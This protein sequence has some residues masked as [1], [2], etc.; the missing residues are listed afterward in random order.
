CQGHTAA[1]FLVS[2][3]LDRPPDLLYDH[4]GGRRGGNP[5]RRPRRTCWRSDRNVSSSELKNTKWVVWQAQVGASRQI[6]FPHRHVAVVDQQAM[7]LLVH[8]HELTPQGPTHFPPFPGKTQLPL[9][10]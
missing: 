4:E 2:H 1:L 9:T 8:A 3:S 6:D 10:S 5:T 7:A